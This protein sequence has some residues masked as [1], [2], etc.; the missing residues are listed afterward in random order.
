ML[1]IELFVPRG[2]LSIHQRRA[3]SGRLIDEVMR[4]PDAPA[5]LD[6]A[7]A[8]GRALAQAV[9]QESDAWSSG[10]Q[11]VGP[12]DGARYVVRVTLPAGHLTDG[13]RAELI[14]RITQVVAAIDDQ[15]GRLEREPRLW[16]YLAEVPDGNM[17]SLGRVLRLGDL[18]NVL[19][20]PDDAPA[21]EPVAAAAAAANSAIDPVC[22]MPV[23]L[24]DTAITLAHD[25]TT[26]AF[27]CG[28]CRDVFIARRGA[29]AA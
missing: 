28:G 1:F 4:A 22:G 5:T 16:I 23:A 8:R 2:T 17:G 13:M 7:I 6:D 26:Y 15:P 3:L 29:P 11:V 20:R 19:L 12:P 18:M 27:C 25:G 10:G 24:T 9:V 21:N 14:T